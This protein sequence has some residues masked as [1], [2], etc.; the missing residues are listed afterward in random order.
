MLNAKTVDALQPRATR[1]IVRD[2]EIRGLELRV[3]PDGTKV[4][5][6]RYRFHGQRRRLRLG[7]HAPNRLTLATAR[8]AAA[9]ALHQVEAGTDPQAARHAA[10][11]AAERARRDTI[12]ALA[13]AYLERAKV[14]KRTWR[15]DSAL[16]NGQIL[17]KWRGRAVSSIT[18][19]DCRQLVDAIAARGAPMYANRVVALLSVLFRYAV[20]QEIIDRSP[21][22]RL[23]KPGVEAAARPESQRE[24]KAY[25]DE[26]IRAIWARTATLPPA[27]RA[28]YRLQ[29]VTGQR[30]GEVS[31][32]AWPE[33]DGSWWTIP[34]ARTKNKRT[35][36]V[37]LSDLALEVLADVPRV[38]GVTAAFAGSRSDER[39]QASN[40]IAFA[41]VRRR[42]N[43]RHAIRNTVAT[44]LA[45]AGVAMED[46]A[47]VLNHT[48]GPKVTQGYNA[49][50]YD[51]ETR[52]ALTRWARRLRQILD[53]EDAAAP[54]V[55]PIR[56]R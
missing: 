20:D 24:Q 48:Y 15:Y 9:R 22:V 44:G 38:E 11:A 14:R 40:A 32:L 55:V 28:I 45:A 10:R 56:G 26:E 25:T 46:I 53:A 27:P 30:P 41:D 2:S 33:I 12:D 8:V 47:K 3:S 21:A 36:R 19:R 31:K 13:T 52:L 42:Q 43:P 1:Y 29:L 39:L 7:L 16:L 54:R 4:W 37:Y 17:P 34:G 49:Y 50:S 18:R 51:K 35:H 23:P 5:T 6:L